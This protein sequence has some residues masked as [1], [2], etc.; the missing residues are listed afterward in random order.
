MV[1]EETLAINFPSTGEKL[2]MFL[3]EEKKVDP[4][5]EPKL[6]FLTPRISNALLIPN[7]EIFIFD[8]F[9]CEC[10]DNHLAKINLPTFK[11]IAN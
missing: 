9:V 10:E 7:S 3:P 11:W 1:V 4:V 8:V 5:E 6:F 2:S